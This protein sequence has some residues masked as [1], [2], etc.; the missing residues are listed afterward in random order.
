DFR[1]T[2]GPRIQ[3]Y[4]DDPSFRPGDLVR[5]TPEL[6]AE[7]RDESG[8][9]TAATLGRRI[10]AWIDDDPTSLDLSPL[11]QLLPGQPGA[12][13]V[14]KPLLGLSPGVHRVRLRAWDVYGN[15]S[16]AETFFRISPAL[17]IEELAAV[18]NPAINFPIRFSFL[19]SG[20][21]PMPAELIVADVLGTV[22][23]RRQIEL[24]PSRRVEIV[25]DGRSDQGIPVVSGTYVYR[26][27]LLVPDGIAVSRTFVV[28]R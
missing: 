1:D 22:L 10:E 5:S 9:N 21:N 7:L 28:I 12:G 15:P 23:H 19:F 27:R 18:P 8:I 11:F 2:T 13:V 14:R 26:V 25:W 16:V 6:I 4:L 3:L 24:A 20:V 17:S